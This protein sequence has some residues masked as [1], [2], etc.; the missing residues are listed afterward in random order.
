MKSFANTTIKFKRLFSI[1][2]SAFI[3]LL[4]VIFIAIIAD[5]NL[6]IGIAIILIVIP[7][8]IRYFVYRLARI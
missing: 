4:L 2:F 6:N 8:A 7:I 1:F 3:V 5:R